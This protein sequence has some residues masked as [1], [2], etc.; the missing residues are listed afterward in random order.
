MKPAFTFVN[1]TIDERINSSFHN[2]QF[3]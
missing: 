2:V 1:V 3:E